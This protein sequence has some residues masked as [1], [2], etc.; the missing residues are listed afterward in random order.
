[1][2]YWPRPIAS[3]FVVW[4]ATPPTRMIA[5]FQSA[6]PSIEMLFGTGSGIVAPEAPST[7]EMNRV[8]LLSQLQPASAGN[9]GPR[10]QGHGTGPKLRRLA[11]MLRPNRPPVVPVIL[12]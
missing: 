7:P 9:T 6:T 1:S 10:S 3:P 2:R 12:F 11:P 5:W 4:L 8:P